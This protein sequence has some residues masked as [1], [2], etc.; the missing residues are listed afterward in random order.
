MALETVSNYAI[1][2]DPPS[3]LSQ[4]SNTRSPC[5]SHEASESYGDLL[6]AYQ[7]QRLSRAFFIFKAK[8]NYFP[9]TLQQSV[10]AFRLR[11]AGTVA[12]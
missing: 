3:T 8:L 11:T 9:N 2:Q 10:Q 12:T 7:I 4:R 1:P 5:H 6:D